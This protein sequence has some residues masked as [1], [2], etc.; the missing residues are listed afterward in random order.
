MNPHNTPFSPKTMENIFATFNSENHYLTPIHKNT[1][2]TSSKKELIAT[3]FQDLAKILQNEPIDI[4]TFKRLSKHQKTLYFWSELDKIMQYGGF[5]KYY[6]S[7]QKN[8]MPLIIQGFSELEVPAITQVL[9]EVH[10]TYLVNQKYFTTDDDSFDAELYKAATILKRFDKKY[11]DL[12]PKI[13][14][15]LYN[16]IHQNPYYFFKEEQGKPF[17]PNFTGTCTSYFEEGMLKEQFE[18]IDGKIEEILYVYHPNGVTSKVIEYD[19]GQLTGNRHEYYP[20]KK[21]KLKVKYDEDIEVKTILFYHE[22][23]KPSRLEQINLKGERQ[24]DYK[25]W[26]ANGQLKKRGFFLNNKTKDG[27]WITFHD[28]GIQQ[29]EAEYTNGQLKIICQWDRMG[30][31]L[32]NPNYN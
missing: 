10:N 29:L 19:Q 5:I 7:P 17:P 16:F 2:F 6:C 11:L 1:F 30:N 8:Y 32:V 24:G 3:I 14:D 31:K 27:E 21:P 15:T 4:N 26:H 12:H 18:V 28:N 13:T 9:T 22:N 20:N 25:E 23:G